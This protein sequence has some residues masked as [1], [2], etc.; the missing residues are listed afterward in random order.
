[1]S[2]LEKFALNAT[3]SLESLSLLRRLEISHRQD[4]CTVSRA[5]ENLISFS[6]ND[7]LGM[8]QHPEVKQAA[9]DA[10]NKY[11]SGAGASRLVTGN[12]PLYQELERKLA[13]LKNTESAI[14]TGSGYLVNI[15]VIPAVTNRGDL[16]LSDRLVHASILDGVMISRAQT[17]RFAHNDYQ[18]LAKLLET[19]RSKFRHCLI[20]IEHVYGMDGDI[21]DIDKIMTLAKQY[22]C[23]VLADDAHGFGIIDN[24]YQQKPDLQIGTLSK[25]IGAYGGYVCTSAAV[26]QYL[27]NKM[28]SLVYSTAL[29]P[30]VIAAAN[31]AL[32]L[33]IH[34]PETAQRA[35]YLARIFCNLLDLPVSKSTIVPIILESSDKALAISHQLKKH[36]FLASAIRPPTVSTPRLRLTFCANHKE[37]DVRR[38]ASTLKQLL[39]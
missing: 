17:I 26:A 9:I 11:G 25:A 31:A 23:W 21:A 7:Y 34:Q 2:C 35:M 33:I 37:N 24:K 13:H 15:G 38:L 5:E 32:D 30:M 28:R 16:I 19:H 39:Q 1:M 10:V 18:A 12:H 20:V 27:T 3:R 6:C 4:N 14:I 36:G 29:P 8:T 22:N